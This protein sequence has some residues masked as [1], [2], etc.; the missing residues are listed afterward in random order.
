[1]D[2]IQAK[3]VTVT[4]SDGNARDYYI[5][6][7]PAIAGREILAKYPLSNMPKL[8]DYEV[9]RETMI[10]LMSFVAV[11]L[12][13]GRMQTLKTE[14]LIDNHVNDSEALLRLE[15]AS[16]E[17]NVSFFGNA[18]VKSFRDYLLKT[19]TDIYLS[20]TKT[21]MGSSLLS[22]VQDWQRTQSSKKK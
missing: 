10:K 11:E 14:A 5:G 21:P 13:D 20:L 7:Y 18:G 4:D 12:E 2:L 8:A 6:K 15:I 17:Y 16:L 22:S 9:S 3:K 19:A 1:M